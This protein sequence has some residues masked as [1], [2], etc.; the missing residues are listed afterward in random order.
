MSEQGH[1]RTQCQHWDPTTSKEL[2]ND[3]SHVQPLK[4][5]EAIRAGKLTL[6][7]GRGEALPV[8]STASTCDSRVTSRI[9]EDMDAKIEDE[10]ARD[11]RGQ[12]RSVK[13]GPPSTWHKNTTSLPTWRSL[14]SSPSTTIPTTWRQCRWTTLPISIQAIGSRESS[15]GTLDTQQNDVRSELRQ[16][17][18]V[19]KS[20][21]RVWRKRG[22]G[23]SKS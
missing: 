8:P 16:V 10:T 17:R 4:L 3:S 15:G 7:Q 14:Y 1:V 23:R 5:C 21:M 6:R 9:L 18:G 22:H 20:T 19:P 2:G 11:T 12:L 13:W